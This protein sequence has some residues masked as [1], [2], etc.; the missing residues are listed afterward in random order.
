MKVRLLLVFFMCCIASFVAAQDK[1]NDNQL[2][3]LYYSKGEYQKA[4]EIYESLVAQSH[5]QIHFDY[6]VDC[7]IKLGVYAKAEQVTL[8]QI[9]YF[10]Q[11]FYYHIAL[12]SLY[13]KQ[14]KTKE[15]QDILAKSTKKALRNKLDC[16]EFVNACIDTREFD[17]AQSFLE[18]AVKKYADYEPLYKKQIQVY[19][20][21]LN[22]EKLSTALVQ[23]LETNPLEL[24]FVKQQLQQ[25][26]FDQQQSKLQEILLEQVLSKINES[27]QNIE[28]NELLLWFYIQ[29]KSFKKAF[30]IARSLDI[31]MKLLGERVQDVG[32][33]ALSND[34]YAVA[35]ECFL[36]VVQLGADKPYYF[37]AV[38]MMLET[39]YKSLFSNSMPDMDKIRSIEQQYIQVLQDLGESP[40]TTDVIR[41]LAHIQGFYMQ[42]TDEAINR[43]NGALKMQGIS[44]VERGLCSMELADLYL[45]TNDVWSANLL[46]AKIALDYKNYDM[47][48]Q[49]RFKQ[50]Q[51]AYYNGQFEYAQALLDILKASTTKLIA[52]DAFELAQLIS[53]NTIMDTTT[54]ALRYFSN[55]DLLLFQNNIP[56]A[57]AYL[58][59]IVIAYPGHSLEDDVLMRKALAAQ[60]M[61]DTASMVEYLLQITQRFSYDVYADNAH[62]ILAEYY[63]YVAKQPEKAQLH[64]KT[65]VTEY[66]SSYFSVPARKRY[67][68]MQKL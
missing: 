43:L 59:S 25:L 48:H 4:A 51:I 36:Y 28:F 55:S 45:Y 32:N 23:L 42:K 47:G 18:V 40:Q 44:F 56:K 27:P 67:R 26:L 5:S 14:K 7:Y 46:Y 38:K 1:S 58:D 50:A 30:V 22:Y 8:T 65:L 35:T 21:L 54:Q 24:E 6:L 63:D 61:Q 37:A 41:N 53:E 3:L 60:K 17:V 66:P 39:A 33:I 49:A 15:A 57:Y 2:A 52:N 11:S 64:Y 68:E 10:P 29:E 12:Y 20:K 9:S 19:S 16:I 13:A 34:E 31:R 62:Y